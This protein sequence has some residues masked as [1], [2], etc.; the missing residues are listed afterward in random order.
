LL[1]RSVGHDP[2]CRLPSGQDPPIGVDSGKKVIIK[3][4]SQDLQYIKV[5]DYILFGFL[6]THKGNMF[7]PDESSLTASWCTVVLKPPH[8]PTKHVF[9]PHMELI[10]D[11]ALA[12]AH[13]PSSL[14][15]PELSPVLENRLAR[16]PPAWVLGEQRGPSRKQPMCSVNCSAPV[17]REMV[18]RMGASNRMGVLVQIQMRSLGLGG[19]NGE[20]TAYH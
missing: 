2:I 9:R 18:A 14:P 15:L 19:Q 1:C 4:W 3:V 20:N 5:R 12:P 10:N 7:D 6:E 8:I 11:L 13:S 17:H 16:A